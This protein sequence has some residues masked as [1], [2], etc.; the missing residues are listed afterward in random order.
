MEEEVRNIEASLVEQLKEITDMF[1]NIA[2]HSGKT[3]LKK[4]NGKKAKKRKA[5]RNARNMEEVKQYIS[6]S[7]LSPEV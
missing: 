3:G 7:P 1:K 5:S 2:H 6:N 4:K